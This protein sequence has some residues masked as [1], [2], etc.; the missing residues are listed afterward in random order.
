MSIFKDTTQPAGK[1]SLTEMHQ[2]HVM[3]RMQPE[4]AP[5][6]HTPGLYESQK[7]D[8]NVRSVVRPRKGHDY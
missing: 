7:T 8:K 2:Q 6:T 1:V 3:S 4:D 5:G